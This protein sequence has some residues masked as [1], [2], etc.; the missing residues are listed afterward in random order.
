LAFPLVF[1][2]KLQGIF[3]QIVPYWSLLKSQSL[4]T[5]CLVYNKSQHQ[6]W[7]WKQSTID[8]ILPP[9][10]PIFVFHHFDVAKSKY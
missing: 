10:L 9:I 6:V 3:H 1:P 2:G 5:M 7:G 8:T 4:L